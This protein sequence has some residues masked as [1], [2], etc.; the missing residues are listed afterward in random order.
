[1]TK[2]L[3]LNGPVKRGRITGM[4]Q[5]QPESLLSI[6]IQIRFRSRA[7]RIQVKDALKWLVP[8]AAII[9]RVIAELRKA[10]P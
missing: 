2:K 10:G 4:N 5:N 1:M 6:D 8:L 3:Q 9:V 7:F